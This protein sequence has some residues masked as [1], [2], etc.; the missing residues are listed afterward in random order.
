MIILNQ[1]LRL[2]LGNM[3]LCYVLH[4]LFSTQ[5]ILQLYKNNI[6]PGIEEFCHFSSAADAMYLEIIEGIQTISN[7]SSSVSFSA[8][9]RDFPIVIYKHFHSYC[10]DKLPSLSPQLLE[11]KCSNGLSGKS[12]HFNL[13]IVS[14]SVISILIFLLTCSKN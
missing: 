5:T 8:P 4:K 6:R 3:V 11:I 2:M 13:E 10:S 7:V 9:L 12:N 1:L 14:I